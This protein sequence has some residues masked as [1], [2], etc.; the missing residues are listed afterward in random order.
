MDIKQKSHQKYTKNRTL[1]LVNLIE[2]SFRK[3]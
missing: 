3:N 2:S 1:F